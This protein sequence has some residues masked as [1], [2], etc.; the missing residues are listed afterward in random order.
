MWW[1]NL[2]LQ[3]WWLESVSIGGLLLAIALAGLVGLGINARV[4][5]V[6]DQALK[7]D[8]ELEDRGDDLRV[9]VLDMRHYHRNLVF[10]GP[11]RLG[12]AD[13]ETAYLQLHA[14]I[15]RLEQ[16]GL[17]D[18]NMPRPE[19]LR[20]L[21]DRYYAEFR[22]AIDGYHSDPSAFTLASDDGL[23]I[24]AEL[25]RATRE[26]DRLGEQ[27]AAAALRSVERAATE[28]RI[29]LLTVLGGL[30]LV[31]AYLAYLAVR[32]LRE[33]QR[34]ASELAHALRAKANFIADASHEL[35]TPLT[36]LRA[37]AEV[38]LELD[39]TCVHTELIE[40]IVRESARM[41]RLVE[42][43][44]FLARSD[45]G[46]QPLELELVPVGALFAELAERADTLTREYDTSLRTEL[47]ADGWA[48]LDRA[49]IEQAAL[50]LVDNAAKYSPAGGLVIL[51]SG[52]RGA[53]LIVEVSDQ[54]PGIPEAELP[55]VFERFYRVDKARTRKQGGAGLGL[56][57]AKS[58]VEAHGGRIEAESILNQGTTMR[59]YLP[60]VTMPQPACQPAGHLVAGHTP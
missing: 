19:R 2:H 7:Y 33:Q 27:R 21:T 48:Q 15:D 40:E 31:G 24:L 44:F 52:T 30:I 22:P 3:P 60:L 29:V 41:T 37:N 57:I 45:S 18:P 5:S 8:I 12:L 16:L 38:A 59:F 1:K 49:R 9:G 53:E 39:R 56:A 11:S 23:V 20:Q 35:R 36:V 26:I 10:A 55:L 58:I 54:G 17:D 43:L 28:A 25:E 13:F 4:K 47:A 34:T 42:D 51:S 32:I 50:I 14:Q 46:S 6:T